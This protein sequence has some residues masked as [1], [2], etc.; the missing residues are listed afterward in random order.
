MKSSD[1]VDSSENGENW[2]ENPVL[3]FVP[4]QN[5]IQGF[6]GKSFKSHFHWIS[7]ENFTVAKEKKK[8]NCER[9]L[10]TWIET[11]NFFFISSDFSL[12]LNEDV[13]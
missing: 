8:K 11:Q 13:V 12:R 6:R 3:D 1:E 5:L 9:S 10:R 2:K 7:F 4:L